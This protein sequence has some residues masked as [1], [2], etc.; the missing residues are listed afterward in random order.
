MNISKRY[1]NYPAWIVISSNLLSITI[2]G[3][4]F[5][6]MLRLSWIAALLYLAYI[7]A[8]EYRLLNKNCVNCYYWGKYCGFGKGKL[9]SVFFKKG[10]ISKFCSKEFAW[11]DM[12][13]DILITLI[14]FITGIVLLIQK[15]NVILLLIIITLLVLSTAV[16]G[17]VRTSLT[18]KFCKQKDIGCLADKLFNKS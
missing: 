3:L 15:F 12:I 14:P 18:C 16:T 8:F 7:F 17:F 10:D 11:K 13:P 5:L 1:D 6:I 9:S 4:G 2:Y